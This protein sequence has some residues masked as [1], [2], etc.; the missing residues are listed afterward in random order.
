M[1][2]TFEGTNLKNFLIYLPNGFADWEA[3]FLL[4][5]LARA[6]LPLTY[7][8]ESGET[9]ESIGKMKVAPD[10]AL[11]EIDPAKFDALI[12][13]GS[14]EWT[15]KSRNEAV[16]RLATGFVH[17]GKLVGG[18]CA[19][20]VALARQGLFDE[21]PHTSNDLRFLKHF[22]PEYRGEKLYQ[23]KLAVT[24]GNLISAAGVGPVDFALEI[25]TAIGWKTPLRRQ[26][27]FDLYK[28]GSM[29]PD[30]F[31]EDE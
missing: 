5:T 16:L 18:I 11:R 13:P 19:A 6:G 28:R 30:D 14:D 9:V 20:T 27:W 23:Q 31:W 24:G 25:L 22:V 8:S 10:A 3:A 26:Q 12:L 2:S 21:R 4:P 7:V 17:S 15:D 29:P 1:N